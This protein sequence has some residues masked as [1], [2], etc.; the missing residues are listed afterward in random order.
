M[1]IQDIVCPS[2]GEITKINVFVGMNED[3]A[4]AYDETT[5]CRHCSSSIG[6]GVQY[7]GKNAEV[8]RVWLETAD[9][10]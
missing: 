4:G 8:N 5:R 2:C 9:E 6:Y 7:D 3:E 1:F 10:S